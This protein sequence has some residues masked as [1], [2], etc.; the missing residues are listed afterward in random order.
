MVIRNAT[1]CDAHSQYSGDVRILNGV[2]TEIG[3]SLADDNMIEGNG[4]Y[5]LPGLVDTNVSLK[6]GQLN[7]KNLTA[8]ASTALGGGVSTVVLKSDL[9]PKIDNEITLEFVHQHRYTKAGAVIECSVNA[10]K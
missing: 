4:C 9:V 2:I 7:G 8:L 10:L 1:L 6:D 3:N 5:L